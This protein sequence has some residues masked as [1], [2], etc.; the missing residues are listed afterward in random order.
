MSYK[1]FKNKKHHSRHT[2]DFA[3]I[4]QANIERSSFD[5]SHGHK[6][7]FKVGQLI[8]VYV[9]EVLPG[10]TFNLRMTAFARLATPI[11]PI[12]DNIYMD[13][14][15]FSVPNR[16]VWDNWKK[17]NGERVNP[18]DSPNFTIPV[19]VPDAING[20]SP[21]GVAD[22]FG[23]PSGKVYN[24]S[25]LFHRAYRLI[26][27]EWYR[28][29]NLQDSLA[30][31]LDDGPDHVNTADS[32]DILYRNKQKDYF[33]G[34]LPWP[35]KGNSPPIGLSGYAPVELIPGSFGHPEIGGFQYG[36]GTPIE[37]LHTIQSDT[38]G[39]LKFENEERW[40]VYDPQGTL[41]TN[42]NGATGI[43]I[44]A[45]R[46][47]FQIQRL[48]ERDARGGTRYTEIVKS[49]FGVSSPDS[50]LQRPE[51]LGGSS[52]MINIS[53]VAQTSGTDVNVSPQ[54]NLAATGTVTIHGAGFTKS[55][56][57]HS[58]VIG[59]V[60]VRVDLTYQQGLNRMFSRQ[61]RFDFYWPALSH[62]GEQ[63]VLRKEIHLLGTAGDDSD[64]TVFGYQ[65]RYAEYRYKPSIITGLFR[66]GHDTSLDA[67]H[68][69]EY[70]SSITAPILSEEFI[71]CGSGN[72]PLN[73]AIAVSGEDQFIFDS[74]I[75]LRCA[76]PMPA[77][78]VPGLIDHF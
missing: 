52:D 11:F 37:T 70:W 59:L 16:L 14:H 27:N 5:R 21:K 62:L 32:D 74:H 53:P 1:K 71:S 65:E 26:W 78:S 7:T 57:E 33:T 55:F 6:T 51:Y 56:T 76:R 24:P 15:F 34:C 73:R 58:I 46:E 48:L 9:D 67:W 28:D 10:D 72:I 12:M 25:A 64:D 43:T 29:E 22:Y 68:L 54:G 42:L 69:S 4:P 19:L 40:G 8:P 3:N 36:D 50:R 66:S 13:T 77:Y 38:S 44:N 23:M 45:L 30:I 60:S 35:Q 20:F 61:T 31:A 63:A 2:H 18:H 39:D 41:H 17:F 75:K 47:A 49:H